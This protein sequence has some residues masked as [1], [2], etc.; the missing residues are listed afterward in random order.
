M[1]KLS[2]IVPVYNVKLYIDKCITSILDQTYHDFELILVDDGS[3]DGSGDVCETYAKL[4][5]RVQVY[6]QANQG[7]A[8]ARNFAI[9]KA[10]GD[11][12]G[13]VDS[14]DWIQPEMFEYMMTAAKDKNADVVVCRL[15]T[16]SEDGNVIDVLGYEESLMMDKIKATEEILRDNNMQSFPVNKIYKKSL[17]NG[18]RFP[19]N[20]FFEDTAIIY[21]VIYNAN[22]ILTIPYIG[23]NYRFNPNSTCHNKSI[24]YQKQVKREYD[25]AL[26]FG[27]R[28]MFCKKDARLK[29]VLKD[30]ANKAYMRMRAFIHLQVHKGLELTTDQKEE[31][32]AIMKSFCLEDLQDFSIVQKMDMI[33]YQY[34]KPLLSLYLRILALI[35][36]MSRDL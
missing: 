10:N 29:N 20:R 21:K 9:G 34:S 30:C 35:H 18:L 23:Y 27:E 3:V 15:Q 8:V 5:L 1:P 11:Y 24:D 17:F 16:V 4:D 32:D 22:L 2:I 14:D 28:Y 13:F 12:I 26:A 19:S 33:V 6:H 25:N 36:P 31:I 7:Q